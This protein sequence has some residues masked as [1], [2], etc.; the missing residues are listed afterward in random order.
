MWNK[1]FKI[2]AVFIVALTLWF[3]FLTLRM[4]LLE[5]DQVYKSRLS[6]ARSDMAAIE[7]AI[8]LY[9]KDHGHYPRD[10]A[11]LTPSAAYSADAVYLQR[12]PV[13][14]WNTPYHLEIK[15]GV[16]G[17]IPTL[18]TVPD[19]KTQERAKLARLADDTVW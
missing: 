3:V 13:S 8:A 16:A 6:R 17:D 10:I 9:A 4:G 18:W 14:P 5:W 19:R 15:H 7:T 1:L 12:V 2:F 11:E